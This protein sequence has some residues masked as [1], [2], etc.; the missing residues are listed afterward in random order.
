MGDG[1]RF[2]SSIRNLIEKHIKIP[3]H[4]INSSQRTTL[5][6]ADSPDVI[7]EEGRHKIPQMRSK[8]TLTHYTDD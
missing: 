5:R 8:I 2:N 1:T 7:L 4:L 3:L 6:N